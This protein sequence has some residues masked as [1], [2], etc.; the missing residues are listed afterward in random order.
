MST[1]GETSQDLLI[2]YDTAGPRY[3][4]YPTAPVWTDRFGPGDWGDAPEEAPPASADWMDA[5][6]EIRHTFTHFHLRLAVRTAQLAMKTT[7][8]RGEFIPA[9]DFRPNDLPT[10]MRK[11]YT[12]VAGS[13][14]DS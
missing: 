8:E 4:S 14:V 7:P 1:Y 12:L 6:V 5:D 3:T 9:S 10:V 11:A 13:L 2:R